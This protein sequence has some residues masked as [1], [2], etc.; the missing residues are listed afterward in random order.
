MQ[1]AGILGPYWRFIESY[2]LI[3]KLIFWV[4]LLTKHTTTPPTYVG[5]CILCWTVYWNH[6]AHPAPGHAYNQPYWDIALERERD[7][8]LAFAYLINHFRCI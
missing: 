3:N 2:C 1:F 5:T 6:Y 8:L 4:I 7:V